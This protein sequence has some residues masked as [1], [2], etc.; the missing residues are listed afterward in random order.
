MSIVLPQFPP[1]PE[2]DRA[3]LSTTSATASDSA[4]AQAQNPAP[5]SSDNTSAKFF[6]SFPHADFILRSSDSHE[7]SVP[8]LY[9]VHS[10]PVLAKSIRSPSVSSD[11]VTSHTTT[12]GESEDESPFDA[13]KLPYSRVIISSL[14]TFIFPVSTVL[15]STTEEIMELLSAAQKYDME[16]V[17]TRIRDLLS[18]QDPP[19][20]RA[21]NAF[22]IFSLAQ[23]YG[24]RDEAR[25]AARSSLSIS[26]TF[27]DLDEQLET[28]PG[29]YLYEL[30]KY[31]QRVRDNLSLDLLGFR[32]VGVR[33]ALKDRRCVKLSS[34]AIPSW[35]D[36]YIESITKSPASFDL[37]KFH[38]SLTY[39]IAAA[40]TPGPD[41]CPCASM[42]SETI[43]TLW[44]ALTAVVDNS[45]GRVSTR[46][47]AVDRG[48]ADSLPG[49]IR[50]FAPYK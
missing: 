18:R 4:Q 10:S 7:F 13:V 38:L 43:R 20:F 35:L 21:E 12:S 47:W 34:L 39:H 23:K 28:M 41:S 6:D 11:G 30:W 42:S 16:T 29:S 32:M 8:K 22:H 37:T 45:F 17:L 1:L 48:I 33:E 50:S 19:F 26:M 36:E 3:D 14:L 2:A 31:H 9:I 49:R 27:D 44:A 15:P 24:L 46:K 25:H 40:K 5:S